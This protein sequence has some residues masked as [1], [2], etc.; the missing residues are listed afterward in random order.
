[1]REQRF[2]NIFCETVLRK[3]QSHSIKFYPFLVAYVRRYAV[4]RIYRL[5]GFCLWSRGSAI[6]QKFPSITRTILQKNN[7]G[8][9]VVHLSELFQP[10]TNN[11][12]TWMANSNA[13]CIIIQ[14]T[15]TNDGL[16][17][18][19]EMFN[20]ILLVVTITLACR[21]TKYFVKHSIKYVKC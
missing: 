16:S 1:M 2:C 19:I 10:L 8:S 5:K 17:T 14:L 3:K 9:A 12:K 18:P 20:R 13:C 7:F 11:L 6:L 15:Q 4:T 21:C